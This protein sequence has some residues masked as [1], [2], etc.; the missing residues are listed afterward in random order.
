[1]NQNKPRYFEY[2]SAA[3]PVINKIEP[4]KLS[5]SNNDQFSNTPYTSPNM[6]AFYIIC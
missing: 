2:T 3:V 4:K 6:Y 5:P 1:M